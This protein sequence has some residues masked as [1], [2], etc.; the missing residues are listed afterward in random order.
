YVRTKL[1]PPAGGGWD[2]LKGE[3][4]IGDEMSLEPS[5][6]VR[7]IPK[8][9]VP[10]VMQ[11]IV[12]AI[13]FQGMDGLLP[14][15]STTAFFG[16]GV[17]T[18]EP[19][20]WE[21]LRREKDELAY[22]THGMEWDSLNE[23]QQKLL[24]RENKLLDNLKREA[25][26]EQTVFPFLEELKKEQMMAGLDVEAGL[27]KETQKEM[28]RLKVRVGPLPRSFGDWVL[29]DERY[30]KYKTN[31]TKELQ[32]Q[33]SSVIKEGQWKTK[34][35]EEQIRFVEKAIEVARARAR[36]LIRIESRKTRLPIR[37]FEEITK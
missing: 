26:Y 6:L 34:S 35:K 20:K 22:M 17:G 11:D 30:E 28:E 16:M 37:T 9:V 19:S 27:L 5:F 32:K 15:T 33:L 29:N 25:A 24:S 8:R 1:S 18:W 31:I 14:V 2:A 36:T 3:T 7:D 13:R 21:L 23:V 4:F 12:E 10:M